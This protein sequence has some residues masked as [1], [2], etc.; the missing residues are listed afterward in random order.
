MS[1]ENRNFFP[2]EQAY[3]EWIQT[4]PAIFSVLEDSSDELA[5][6]EGPYFFSPQCLI[7]RVKRDYCALLRVETRQQA[8]YTWYVAR[9][10]GEGE[11]VFAAYLW[12]KQGDGPPMVVGGSTL[13]QAKAALTEFLRDSGNHL[14]TV[15]LWPV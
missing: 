9:S 15:R 5:E 10:P 1:T 3:T 11:E 2:H 8:A 4:I 12:H 7:L 13:E 6:T 14:A